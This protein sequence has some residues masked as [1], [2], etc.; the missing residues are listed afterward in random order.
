[1]IPSGYRYALFFGVIVQLSLAQEIE[2]HIGTL[3]PSLDNDKYQFKK[4]MELANETIRDQGLLK[5]YKLVFHHKKTWVR[6]RFMTK[7]LMIH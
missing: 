1:M 7:R 5:G 2:L 3:I 4:A 6:A